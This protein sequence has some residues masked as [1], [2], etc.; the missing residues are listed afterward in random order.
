MAFNA[1]LLGLL[2]MLTLTGYW[3]EIVIIPGLIL[4]PRYSGEVKLKLYYCLGFCLARSSID[5]RAVG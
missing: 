4:K 1:D 5:R 3:D 2:Y